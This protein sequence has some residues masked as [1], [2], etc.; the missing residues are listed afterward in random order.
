MKKLILSIAVISAMGLS[1]TSNA[2]PTVG[3]SGTIT[4]NGIINTDSC[5]VHSDGPGSSG[6]NL[7]YNLG[8]V[9]SSSLGSEDQPNVSTTNVTALPTDLNLVIECATT[10]TS[11]DLKLTPTQTSGKGIAVTGGAQNVQIMLTKA[12]NSII[13]FTSG[14]S[15]LN[16]LVSGGNSSMNLKAYYT[17][18]AGKA[19]ADV[20][21]GQA[22]ATV[23]YTLSYN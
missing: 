10:P 23:A 7:T 8:T 9:S 4:F 18:K 22:N 19:V 21:A 13:D 2:A 14:S 5:V 1:A 12:D 20:T 15:T 16:G 3:A 11:V 17:R 6:G